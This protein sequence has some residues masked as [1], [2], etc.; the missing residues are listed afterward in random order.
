ML[1]EN[2]KNLRKNKGYTQEEL[3]V[4][5]HVTRQTISKWEKGAS[6]PDASLLS[7]LAEILEVSVSELLGEKTIERKE[8][9][10]VIEQLSRINEQMAVR[11]R[12][13]NR[14]LKLLGGALILVAAVIL[15][16]LT[17][18]G[19]SYLSSHPGKDHLGPLTYT[20]PGRDFVHEKNDIGVTIEED[21]RERIS[22]KGYKRFSDMTEI[23]LWGY[24]EPDEEILKEFEDSHAGDLRPFSEEYGPLPACIDEI[25][26]A[27]DQTEEMDGSYYEA[28]LVVNHKLYNV[29]VRNGDDPAGSGESLISSMEL[30]PEY[31][32]E[33]RWQKRQPASF[34]CLPFPKSIL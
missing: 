13:A 18:R 17:A 33:Y 26:A 14:M 16:I 21:G 10:A 23:I 29:Q 9:D 28:W 20:L 6:V 8:Q 24:D 11:S 15:G 27:S 3:A 32:E 19:T 22:A 4:R 7:D 30:E 1:N 34:R 31:R 25:L 2:I 12:N 5:L